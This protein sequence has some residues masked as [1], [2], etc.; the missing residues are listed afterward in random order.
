MSYTILRKD[1][2]SIPDDEWHR[3]TQ[4]ST[5]Q[6]EKVEQGKIYPIEQLEMYEYWDEDTPSALTVQVG[7]NHYRNMKVQP[8]EF[9]MANDL[10][11]PVG[12]I[13]KYA[14]RFDKK[15][16]SVQD[17]QKVIHYAQILIEEE[18]KKNA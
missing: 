8:I 17:L 12:N 16:H 3:L 2:T 14:C 9:I 15:G 1:P 4:S 7:G 5:G 13:I 11:F 6:V 18:N 10:S